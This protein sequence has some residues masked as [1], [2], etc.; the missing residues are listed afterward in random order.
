M[1][2]LT[3]RPAWKRPLYTALRDGYEPAPAGF[4]TRRPY[5][6]WVVVGTTC[7]A[8]FIGQ[9]DASIVQLIL[10][11]LEHEFLARLSEVSWVAIA[12]LLAYAAFLPVFARIAGIAGRKLMYLIGFALF[13]LASALC[14]L[15]SDLAQ[16]IAFRALLGIAGAMLGANSIVIL[17][18]AAGPSRQGRAMGIFAAAQAVGVTIGPVVG[19]VLLAALG[20]RWVFWVSVP[21][22]LAGAVS[23]GW[24]FHKRPI[25]ALIGGSTGG[26]RYC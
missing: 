11:T 16:L 6:P 5:Y 7:I 22:A 21:L 26:G 19:G 20:W 15:A 3:I 1:S 23:A 12:Y 17:V 13:R 2:D 4:I 8:A 9:L 10:P 18:R 14:G 25:S 24:S